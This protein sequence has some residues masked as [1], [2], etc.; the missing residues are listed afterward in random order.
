MNASVLLSGKILSDMEW[1]KL[2]YGIHKQD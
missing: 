1:Q 2:W